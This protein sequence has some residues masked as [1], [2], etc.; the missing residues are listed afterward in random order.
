MY[1]WDICVHLG[2]YQAIAKTL[3]PELAVRLEVGI[4]YAVVPQL[5]ARPVPVIP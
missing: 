2:Y 3:K 4:D 1:P 5:E